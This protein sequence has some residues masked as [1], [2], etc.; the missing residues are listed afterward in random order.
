MENP[1]LL[2]VLVKSLY[3]KRDI[4]QGELASLPIETP[5]LASE[6]PEIIEQAREKERQLALITENAIQNYKIL[7]ASITPSDRLPC[8]L[9]FV[10][11]GEKSPIIP[12][13]AI[14]NTEPVKCTACK[15]K[16]YIH[17]KK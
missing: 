6:Q 1:D 14:G 16:F 10:F 5:E 11:D 17:R 12:L 13:N 15:E 3:E 2:A 7:W 8:P 9:C 4:L